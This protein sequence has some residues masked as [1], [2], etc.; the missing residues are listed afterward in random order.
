MWKIAATFNGER[1]ER[2]ISRFLH[3]WIIG[4]YFITKLQSGKWKMGAPKWVD[5]SSLKLTVRP[6]KS[7]VGRCIFYWNSTF[8]GDMLVSGRVFP[9]KKW[10]YS[11]DRYVIVY[12]PWRC[13]RWNI[14]V[15]QWRQ[16]WRIILEMK[17][18]L[19]INWECGKCVLLLNMI[20]LGQFIATNP[21]RSSQKVVKSKG[22]LFTWGKGRVMK[23]YNL[24]RLML[25]ILHPVFIDTFLKKTQDVLVSRHFSKMIFL[26]PRWDTLVPLEGSLSHDFPVFDSYH[27]Y[28]DRKIGPPSIAT[29]WD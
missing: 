6:W 21:P 13:R 22:N 14:Y 29:L 16:P 5:V 2:F 23:Y 19:S 1:G 26:L 8:L 24:A 27:P 3:W 4:S 7:M 11:S 10:W 17:P 20:D 15:Q 18:S 12:L 25:D 28:S 9:I